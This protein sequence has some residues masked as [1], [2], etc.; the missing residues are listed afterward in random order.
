MT[1]LSQR[2]A[3]SRSITDIG[4]NEDNILTTCSSD[5]TIKIW[6]IRNPEEI[7]TLQKYNFM[8]GSSIIQWNRHDPFKFATVQGGK[9]FFW[10]LKNPG[11]PYLSMFAEP[12][13]ISSFQWS[14]HDPNQFCT[15]NQT[16]KVKIWSTKS[17]QEHIGVILTPHSVN[18]AKYTPFGS[19]IVTSSKNDNFLHMYKISNLNDVSIVK[20]FEGRSNENV[21]DLWWR[22]SIY[23]GSVEFQLVTW[24][25]FASQLRLTHVEP[26][27]LQACGHRISK[28]Q[29]ESIKNE[30][31]SEV[32]IVSPGAV[33]IMT[34]EEEFQHLLLKTPSGAKIVKHDIFA[35]TLVVSWNDILIEGDLL[36][37]EFSFP[38]M[39]PHVPPGINILKNEVKD[40][41]YIKNHLTEYCDELIC[42]EKNCIR[43][44]I[45]KMM[46]EI[47]RNTFAKPNMVDLKFNN[48]NNFKQLKPST[49]IKS[50][51]SSNP[52]ILKKLEEAG[53]SAELYEVK[54]TD[55]ISSIAL[56][57]GTTKNVIKNVNKMH[58]IELWPG[59]CI[60][61][62]NNKN[63]EQSPSQ[64]RRI[65]IM[66]GHR[67]HVSESQI[68]NLIDSR[69][70]KMI[71]SRTVHRSTVSYNGNFMSAL[72]SNMDSFDNEKKQHY[73]WKTK[74]VVPDEVIDYIA[75]RILCT[76]T[77]YPILTK[78]DSWRTCF[79]S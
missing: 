61:V 38:I 74:L 43:H 76:T 73:K 63:K 36:V 28:K 16:N 35:R 49:P 14:I 68:E 44:C 23:D 58:T 67:N 13:G 55:S 17:P 78:L 56:K 64:K 3:H 33:S 69:K 10:D 24:S 42:E 45:E 2:N 79:N 65:S 72:P 15:A 52:V 12:N 41:L 7:T 51:V 26:K 30:P 6:D 62:I 5:D 34:M 37:V 20:S 75:V 47:S 50:P 46:R 57:F 59:R 70:S 54:P 9:I 22:S 77:K 71:N 27:L 39:Y 31:D 19:G 18:I 11:V 40:D 21:S 25:K 29:L 48:N 60:I 8:G 1:K 4:W 32:P 66:G 53:P